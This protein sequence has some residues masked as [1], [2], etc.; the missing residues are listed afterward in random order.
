MDI[1]DSISISLDHLRGNDSQEPRE[2][3]VV[4]P[5]RLKRSEE[6]C[7]VRFGCQAGRRDDE[8]WNTVLLCDRKASCV[9]P[10]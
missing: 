1:D 4:D 7:A 3:D 10:I 9:G 2:H 8:G 6:R 5:P